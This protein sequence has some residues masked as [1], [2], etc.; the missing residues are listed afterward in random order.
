MAR[1]PKRIQSPKNPHPPG[2]IRNEF[3]LMK[4]LANP[5]PKQINLPVGKPHSQDQHSQADHHTPV[6]ASEKAENESTGNESTENNKR[7]P[8]IF[9]VGDSMVRDIK[10][11]LLSRSKTVKV[12]AFPGS[13]TEDME[14]FL[15][16]LLKRTP[17]QILLHVGMNDLKSYSPQ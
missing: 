15:I 1:E 10:G 13:T 7:K 17:N 3:Q 9:L 16:P 8:K 4:T 12:H 11:L 6:S 14:S 2:S 5:R